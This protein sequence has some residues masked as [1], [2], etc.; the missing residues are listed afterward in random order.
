VILSQSGLWHAEHLEGY[1]G[2]HVREPQLQQVQEGITAVT[3]NTQIEFIGG[4]KD[5]F[6]GSRC[7]ALDD[8]GYVVDSQVLPDG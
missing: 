8:S 3:L 4:V 7:L 6:C 2:F 1:L 5:E